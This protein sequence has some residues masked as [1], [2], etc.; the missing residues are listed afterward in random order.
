MKKSYFM[1]FAKTVLSVLVFAAA[2][3]LS[4]CSKENVT[5]SVKTNVNGTEWEAMHEGE[6][7]TLTFANGNY[8]FDYAYQTQKGQ[9]TGKFSQ[10]GV[11]ITF[12][13]KNFLTYAYHTLHA[14]EIAQIG[15]NMTV[16]VYDVSSNHEAYTLNFHLVYK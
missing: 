10:S 5:D 11:D 16:S 2:I 8:T 4:S 7:F 1:V 3:T 9:V 14:G 12:E 15:S 6:T 13:E